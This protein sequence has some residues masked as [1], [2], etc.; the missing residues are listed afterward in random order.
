MAE[1]YV[2]ERQIESGGEIMGL[3]SDIEVPSEEI[4]EKHVTIK[5]EFFDTQTKPIILCKNC[6]VS[7]VTHY[8]LEFHDEA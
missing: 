2:Y 4:E 1:C 6:V 8:M 5:I 3:Q 7:A